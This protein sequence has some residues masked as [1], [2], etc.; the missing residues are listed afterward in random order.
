MNKQLAAV[1]SA[2]VLALLGACGG[3]SSD[4]DPVDKYVGTWSG[5]N[6]DGSG[7]RSDTTVFTKTAATTG[8]LSYKE[9]VFDTANCTGASTPGEEGAATFSIVGTKTI[10]G[11]VVDK[12][13][14]NEGGEF[15]QVFLVSN[16]ALT[17]GLAP[18]DGAT[19]DS[20]GFPN[21]LEA[22]SLGKK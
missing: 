14:G 22:I 15:K 3:G 20:E 21:E 6:Q 7:S 10:N 4:A 2:S 5:C 19:F 11:K 18:E 1:A 8:G 12:I 16:A 13:L 17:I 9:A